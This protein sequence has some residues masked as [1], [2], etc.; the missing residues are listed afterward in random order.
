MQ[1]QN[2][3]KGQGK[4]TK[5]PKE[6]EEFLKTYKEWYERYKVATEGSNPPDEPPPPPGNDDDGD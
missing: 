6:I 5:L 2:K 1:N 4:T 3:K